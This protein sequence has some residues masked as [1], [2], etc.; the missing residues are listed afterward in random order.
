MFAFAIWDERRKTLF[1]A[2]DRLGIKPLHYALTNDGVFLFASEI[3]SILQYEE[4][5]PQLNDQ[6]LYNFLNI[7]YSPGE[8]TFFKG[9][10]RLRPG[11]TLLYKNGKI[12]IRKYWDISVNI[13][14][15]PD[16]YY[17]DTLRELLLTSVERRLISDV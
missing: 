6:A 5:K 3:K 15:H 2:R 12:V 9:I 17:V 8:Q 10:K 11:H 1:L 13:T 7:N 14:N 16:E 4:V